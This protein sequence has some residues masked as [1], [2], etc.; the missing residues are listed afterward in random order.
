M[1]AGREGNTRDNFSLGELHSQDP[2]SAFQYIGISGFCL[3][4]KDVREFHK[5]K[6]IDTTETQRAN[7]ILPFYHFPVSEADALYGNGLMRRNMLNLL[8]TTATT[9][10]SEYRSWEK[11]LCYTTQPNSYG[12][13][14]NHY[15]AGKSVPGRV[16]FACQMDDDPRLGCAT[17]PSHS[18]PAFHSNGNKEGGN[19]NHTTE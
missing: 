11:V 7:I 3:M 4:E 8:I 12:T 18:A 2:Q 19:N 13:V 14:V 17:A 1:A 5:V 16:I 6:L 10:V 9:L 15:S